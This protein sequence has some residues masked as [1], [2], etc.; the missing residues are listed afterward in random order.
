VGERIRTLFERMV[1][2]TLPTTDTVTPEEMLIVVHKAKLF[3]K[4]IEHELSSALP[5][6][7]WNSPQHPRNMSPLRFF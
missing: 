6:P 4:L 7:T 3:G 2:A 5:E 1:R